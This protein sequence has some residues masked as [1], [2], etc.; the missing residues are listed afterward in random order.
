MDGLIIYLGICYVIVILS[1]QKMALAGSRKT[2]ELRTPIGVGVVDSAALR[3]IVR[4]S[5]GSGCPRFTERKRGQ[6]AQNLGVHRIERV[7]VHAQF[8]HCCEEVVGAIC[9]M[10]IAHRG[11]S[12]VQQPAERQPYPTDGSSAHEARNVLHGQSSQ[13]EVRCL[14]R[15][16]YIAGE[17]A[18]VIVADHAPWKPVGQLRAR[19]APSGTTPDHDVAKPAEEEKEQSEIRTDLSLYFSGARNSNFAHLSSR[20]R[21]RLPSH[22]GKPVFR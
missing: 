19:L 15:G 3:V 22:S 6:G 21:W 14:G 11:I 7:E 16:D 4:I 13:R 20:T 10:P 17:K 18:P 2:I 8:P 12:Q 5:G 9:T 1:V